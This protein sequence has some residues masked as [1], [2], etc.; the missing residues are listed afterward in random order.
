MRDLITPDRISRLIAGFFTLLGVTAIA[1]IYNLSKQ[2]E[3][4]Q[5][6]VISGVAT[7]F[8]LFGVLQLVRFGSDKPTSKQS[9]ANFKG[10]FREKPYWARTY[11]AGRFRETLEEMTQNLTQNFVIV[12][13]E[14]GSGKS[15]M[16][17]RELLRPKDNTFTLHIEVLDCKQWDLASLNDMSEVLN[18]KVRDVKGGVDCDLL[19]LDHAELLCKATQ[20][21]H[22]EL[23]GQMLSKLAELQN[24]RVAFVVSKEWYYDLETRLKLHVNTGPISFHVPGISA[25]TESHTYCE[26]RSSLN[27]LG[28]N[29]DDVLNTLTNDGTINPLEVQVIGNVLELPKNKLSSEASDSD[30]ESFPPTDILVERY[31]DQVIKSFR[32]PYR[33]AK[34]C[35]CIST[36]TLKNRPMMDVEEIAQVTF[37]RPDQ[38]KSVLKHLTDEGLVVEGRAKSVRFVHDFVAEKCLL[39]GTLELDPID[40]DCIEAGVA[41]NKSMEQRKRQTKEGESGFAGPISSLKKGGWSIGI[42]AVLVMVRF[43]T[44]EWDVWY[45]FPNAIHNFD[46]KFFA[47]GLWMDYYYLP[48]AITHLVWLYYIN[49]M[50]R[51]FLDQVPLLKRNVLGRAWNYGL[52][53]LGAFLAVVSFF[54]ISLFVTLLAVVGLAYG[55]R[56]LY[57]AGRCSMAGGARSVLLSFGRKTVLNMAVTGFLGFVLLVLPGP[58]LA[59]DGNVTDDDKAAVLFLFY[60]FGV[61]MVYYWWHIRATQWSESA[62]GR[63]LALSWRGLGRMEPKARRIELELEGVVMKHFANVRERDV[64]QEIYTVLKDWVERGGKR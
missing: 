8:L 43:A 17:N 11:L 13:G 61:M 12:V 16:I 56:I 24:T 18:C 28:S 41:R 23:V 51:R 45:L 2:G 29:P 26:M 4:A 52:T 36:S 58:Y 20:A 33:V 19:V 7:L 54:Y 57:I 39:P 44:P 3:W 10:P 30:K 55:A 38:V 49:L 62:I 63:L 34:V 48:A 59:Q 42:V 31:F 14:S 9:A 60:A 64:Q 32:Y 46:M 25:E 6:T 27:A 21:H 15:T 40:R 1:D 5:L 47:E 53:I 50:F 37:M 35:Y 22:S